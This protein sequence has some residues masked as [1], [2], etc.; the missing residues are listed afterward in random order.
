MRCELCYGRGTV[1]QS[2]TCLICNGVGYVDETSQCPDYSGSGYITGGNCRECNGSGTVNDEQCG[3]CGGSG[4]EEDRRC[5]R[6][7]TSG[8]I[9]ERRDCPITVETQVTCQPCRGTGQIPDDT[10][11][12]LQISAKL[13]T[14]CCV[15]SDLNNDRRS[16]DGMTLKQC[17]TVAGELGGTVA[18]FFPNC[19]C[20]RVPV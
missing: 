20:S 14:G 9:T 8:Q 10:S 19:S 15:I 16:F 13:P 5:D 18:G 2:E 4:K 7:E 1:T 12:E 3:S 6:C 17:Y 11:Q